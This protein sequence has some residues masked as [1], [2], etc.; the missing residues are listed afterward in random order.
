MSRFYDIIATIYFEVFVCID[1]LESP[2]PIAIQNLQDLTM[3]HV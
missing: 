3:L 1:C 2:I